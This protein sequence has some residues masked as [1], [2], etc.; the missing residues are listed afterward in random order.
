MQAFALGL[1]L[2][3]S[4]AV[5]VGPMA[6][7]AIHQTLARGVRHGVASSLGAATGDAFYGLVA[8]LGLALVTDAVSAHRAFLRLAGGLFLCALGAFSLRRKTAAGVTP[9]AA[10]SA[11]AAFLAG[12]FL[13]ATNPLTVIGFGAI[14][15][16]APLVHS[17][18]L[19][20]SGV[21]A[22]SFLW[23]AALCAAAGQLRG[24]LEHRL[25]QVQWATAGSLWLGGAVALVMGVLAL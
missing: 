8:A 18:A 9:S 16:Q 13:T 14:L 6:L 11:G 24:L 19:V 20:V 3:L 15:L 17:P 2:G 5:P 1:V 7:L 21:F 22:G 23:Y 4:I 12:L 10:E 25:R